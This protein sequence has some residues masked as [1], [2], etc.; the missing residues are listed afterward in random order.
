MPYDNMMLLS[1]PT[2]ATSTLDAPSTT[3]GTIA[4]AHSFS[5]V[6]ASKARALPDMA[7]R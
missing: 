3:T 1:V 7:I 4:A 2:K 6:A 5:W